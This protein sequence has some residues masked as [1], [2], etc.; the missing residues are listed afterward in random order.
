MAVRTGTVTFLFT[1]I[2]GSTRMWEDHP[3]TMGRALE[4]H[5]QI[6]RSTI[7]EH[8]GHVFA[9]GGDGFNAAFERPI[10]AARAAL[11]AQDLLE[12]T[13]WPTEDPIKVRMGIH[14]GIAE[15]RGGDFFGPPLNYTARVMGAVAGRQVAVSETTFD[16]LR[17]HLEDWGKLSRIRVGKA[18]GLERGTPVYV[19]TRPHAEV[20][21]VR[22]PMA[23]LLAAAAIVV[24]AAAVTAFALTGGDDSGTTTT[25]VAAAGETTTGETEA[26]TTSTTPGDG[27]G[28]DR[29]VWEIEAFGELI[30]EPAVIGD[31]VAAATRDRSGLFVVDET[32]GTETWSIP[33]TPLTT[34]VVHDGTLLVGIRG[35]ILAGYSV[36]D[37]SEEIRCTFGFLDVTAPPTSGPDSVYVAVAEQGRINRLDVESGACTV[38]E[39]ISTIRGRVDAPLALLDDELLALDN[40]G[41][42]YL[43]DA[44][45][46]MPARG[47]AQIGQ[48]SAP[49]RG[50]APPLAAAV[51]RTAGSAGT[52]EVPRVFTVNERGFVVSIDIDEPS[53]ATQDVRTDGRLRILATG[54]LL[55][56]VI[57]DDAV[58]RRL[59]QLDPDTFVPIRAATTELGEISA[60]PV[61]GDGRVYVADG[62]RVLAFDDISL[63]LEWEADLGST[64]VAIAELGDVV[65]VSTG[66][67][68]LIGLDGSG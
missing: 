21:P 30:G 47:S 68:D 41:R 7:E 11:H 14:T 10:E 45:T 51:V 33:G 37:G 5:D 55:A 42:V 66:A 35:G 39:D 61:V 40:L 18:K 4:I 9:T 2:E 24:G 16:L 62:Y 38:A 8:G 34:P 63:Q 23:V 60:G 31:R 57:G 53:L 64:V 19:L 48:I 49:A 28:S 43:F 20:P 29:V 67:G 3:A 36:E 58:T 15:A 56:V 52:L 50:D 27:T 44:D 13:V 12:Q 26:T 46:L 65:V 32:G 59:Q 1:D 22:R 6:V 25:T 54:D 17:H